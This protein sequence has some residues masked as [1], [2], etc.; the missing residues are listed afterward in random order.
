MIIG[1][2]VNK[3]AVVADFVVQVYNPVWA[4]VTSVGSRWG[5]TNRPWAG[6]PGL[7]SSTG[8]NLL[9]DRNSEPIPTWPGYE[10]SAAGIL[11]TTNAFFILHSFALRLTRHR[12]A[13][14]WILTGAG[15][16]AVSLGFRLT[17][18]RTNNTVWFD[19]P[20]MPAPGDVVTAA[21]FNAFLTSLQASVN[22]IR[23]NTVYASDI[24]GCHASC[25][26]A[27]HGSRG[28]R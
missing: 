4:A 6:Y 11:A 24:V 14:G 25:H 3:T 21:T 28:R 19:P 22:S 8:H 5:T 16:S 13:Q 23:S 2:P 9:G 17:S 15:N 20:T 1:S 18:Y 7:T 27:C 26:S 12:Q 10:N